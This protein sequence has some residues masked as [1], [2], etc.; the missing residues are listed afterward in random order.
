MKDY[1][2]ETLHASVE[3][4]PLDDAGKLPLYLRGSYG[5]ERWAI[6]GVPFAIATPRE[7][8]AVKTMAKNRDAMER[9]LGVPVAFLLDEPT[10]Y[11]AGRMLEAGLP[12]VAPDRQI[13]L[14]FLGV[15]LSEG[16]GRPRK[17]R[18]AADALS[19]QAQRLALIM[20]YGR[21]D[22]AS[23]TE[24]AEALGVAKMTASRAFDELEAVD[25]SLVGSEGHRRVLRPDGDRKALWQRLEPHLVSP[26]AREHRLGYVPDAGLSLGGM[27]ALCAHSMLQDNPWPTFAATRAQERELGLPAG[28]QS[29][30]SV[31]I[32]EPACV[33]QVMRY[34]P[35]S[36]TANAID[37][38]SA[39][40]SLSD[41][42]K[43]DPRIAGE[44][45]NAMDRVLG[46][47]DEGNR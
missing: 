24:A 12:F 37:P 31:E 40:L 27:S 8:L 11:R 33:V 4:G 47:G 10:G 6:F 9:A 46:G 20:L 3:R 14:P 34:E 30:E 21:L 1:V 19:P 44:I 41:D 29:A 18:Q 23:V 5:L 2:G 45:E 39:I 35:I 13:Y 15:A 38:L 32:D 43:E 25:P 42:D 17:R 26:V 7:S 22:G 36:G 16:G 28:E